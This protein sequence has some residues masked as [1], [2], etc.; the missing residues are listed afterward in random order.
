ML[1]GFAESDPAAQSQVAAFR[2]ALTKLGWT[3]G[4]NL[5]IEP[6]WGAGDA[7]RIKKLAKE[8]VDLVFVIAP[9]PVST[10]LVESLAHPGGNTT[11]LSLLATDLS[12]K[13]LALLK[14]AFPNL[15]RVAL[16]VDQTDPIK[17]RTVK[18][19]QAAAEALGVSLWTAEIAGPDD[20]E[21]VFAKIAQDHA[22][23]VV[24]GTGSLLFNLRARAAPIR[25]K[26]RTRQFENSEGAGPH[27]LGGVPAA[28]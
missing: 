17:Q 13:R 10:G 16:L 14:E 26:V 19:N 5:R 7:D 15:S 22:D 4:S 9:D 21:G 1:M 20:V 24:F 28:R 27:N 23:G 18:A 6:R 25:G 11:G 8:L 12:G 3:E 2:D